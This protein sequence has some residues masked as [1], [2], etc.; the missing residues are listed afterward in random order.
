MSKKHEPPKVDSKCEPI[1]IFD[2]CS[3]CTKIVKKSESTKTRNIDLR[4]LATTQSL[5]YFEQ[6]QHHKGESVTVWAD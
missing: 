5:Y 2:E 4:V 3:N 6:T 1:P